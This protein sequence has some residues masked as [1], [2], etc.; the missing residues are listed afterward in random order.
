VVISGFVL[1]MVVLTLGYVWLRWTQQVFVI[2]AKAG[3]PSEDSVGKEV[4]ENAQWVPTF[5]GMTRS[6][7]VW[8]KHLKISYPDLKLVSI[9][10]GSPKVCHPG[11]GRGEAC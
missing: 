1:M 10:D 6:M 3:N 7:R 8:K 9:Q 11:D 4:V 5:V 2:P